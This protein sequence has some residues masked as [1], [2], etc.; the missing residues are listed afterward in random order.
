MFQKFGKGILT[1]V[2]AGVVFA[3]C[4]SA[5]ST[6]FPKPLF[7]DRDKPL[8]SDPLFSEATSL[9]PDMSISTN[10]NVQRNVDSTTHVRNQIRDEQLDQEMRNQM[11]AVSNWLQ[12]YII[13]NRNEFPGFTNDNGYAAQV[14]L[15]ELVP[16]NP[17]AGGYTQVM[18]SHGIASQYNPNGSWATGAP[19]WGDQWTEHLQAQQNNRIQLSIDYSINPQ[20]INQWVQEP[21]SSWT[22]APGTISA[23]GNNQGL[24]V[25][26]GAGRDGRPIKSITTGGTFLIAGSGSGTVNDQIAPNEY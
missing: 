12:R 10:T 13:R 24:F 17:Y 11:T 1:G 15:T 22:A 6:L 20:Q 25:V 19:V 26:W 23:I 14:Q 7:S 3:S 4:A 2:A 9:M 16:N 18:G 5:Q 8:F 21:P